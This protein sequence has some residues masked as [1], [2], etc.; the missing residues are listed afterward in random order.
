VSRETMPFERADSVSGDAVLE[1]LSALV[2]EIDPVP[3]SVI[4]AA[5]AAFKSTAE[6]SQPRRRDGAGGE[7]GFAGLS[8][9]L[10][11]PRKLGS[12][13]GGA[14]PDMPA[15]SAEPP[16]GRPGNRLRRVP[17]RPTKAGIHAA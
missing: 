9:L 17:G 10:G 12:L 8:K 14:A 13:A 1:R 5:R 16:T 3:Q 2:E 4:A 7:P 11:P 6:V 15:V